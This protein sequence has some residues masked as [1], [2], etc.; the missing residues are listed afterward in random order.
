[1]LP[2]ANLKAKKNEF[3]YV[4]ANPTPP[5]CNKCKYFVMGGKCLLVK[6]E[7]SGKNGS[8][9]LW[10]K[11]NPRM[12]PIGL[13]SLTQKEAGYEEIIGG[14]RCGTCLFYSQ[15]RECKL[16]QGNIA[17]HTGCCN[18]WKKK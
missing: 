4:D 18:A 7:I 6:G 3:G 10:V 11:G 1:M 13:S 9:N 15:P 8:C 2:L 5:R 14:P 16:V 12:R 17:P